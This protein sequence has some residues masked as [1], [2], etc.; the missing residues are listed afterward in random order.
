MRRV[1]IPMMRDTTG[2]TRPFSYPQRT[3]STRPTSSEAARASDTGERFP[4]RDADTSKPNG[5]VGQLMSD[6]APARIIG[7]F[8][9]LG[10]GHL[11]TGD[12]A[13]RDE[14]VMA[15]NGR[16]NLVRPVFANILDFGVNRLDTV[17][18]PGPLRH[19]QIVFVLARQV[20]PVVDDSIGTRDLIFQAQVNPHG[21]QAKLELGLVFDLAVQIEVPAP[22]GVLREAAE[23]DPAAD[24]T[25]EP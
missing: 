3:Q 13:H 7:R 9:H 19:R 15:G 2:A 16:R 18:F 10:C 1:D 20:L 5:F 6:H 12:I 23:F 24:T 21:I 8:G 4:D 17:L 25:R 14:R 22:T 11:G